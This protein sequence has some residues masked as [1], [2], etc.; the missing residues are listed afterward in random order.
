MFKLFIGLFFLAALAAAFWI[1]QAPHSPRVQA[2]DLYNCSD[3]PNQAAAQA[4][5]RS[6]PS[7]PSHLDATMTGLRARA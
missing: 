1:V 4:F 5:L 2:A 7:D 3:F 6:D